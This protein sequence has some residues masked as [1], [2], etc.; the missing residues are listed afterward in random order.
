MKVIITHNFDK[1]YAVSF[2]SDEDETRGLVITKYSDILARECWNKT[3][4]SELFFHKFYEHLDEKQLCICGEIDMK[5]II[6][7]YLVNGVKMYHPVFVYADSNKES[8]MSIEEY[9]A[10]SGR[11]TRT[12]IDGKPTYKLI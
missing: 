7:S 3:P 8:E 10:V 11:Y 1:D 12:V 5:V 9:V 2:K 4:I 6:Q